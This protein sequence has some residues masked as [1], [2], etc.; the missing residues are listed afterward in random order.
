MDVDS[1]D[2]SALNAGVDE[3]TIAAAG[4]TAPVSLNL[5]PSSIVRSEDLDITITG[6][7]IVDYVGAHRS[8]RSRD[9]DILE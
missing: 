8:S 9:E 2:T 1:S 6:L 3:P 7:N 4:V 5:I